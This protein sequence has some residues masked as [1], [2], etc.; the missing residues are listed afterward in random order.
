[1]SFSA[2]TKLHGPDSP[3][4]TCG[5]KH[6]TR[7]GAEKCG[8]K[9]AGANNFEISERAPRPKHKSRSTRLSEALGQ[10]DAQPIHDAAQEAQ[11]HIDALDA[12]AEGETFKG[13]GPAAF[14]AS[15]YDVADK[16]EVESLFDEIDQ[17]KSGMEGTNFEASQKYSDLEECATALEEIKD[18]LDEL[19]FSITTPDDV[20][21]RDAWE[22]YRDAL[23]E[24]ADGIEEVVGN[25]GDVNFPGMF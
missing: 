14:D 25:E 13:D 5:H 15:E 11:D 19:D 9:W 24:L 12:L 1:M 16:T 6:T 17:W 2:K 23:T 3:T 10:L 21:N 20:T 4:V 7:E 18:K 22:T 8:T